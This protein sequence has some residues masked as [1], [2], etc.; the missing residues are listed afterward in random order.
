MKAIIHLVLVVVVREEQMMFENVISK[1]FKLN[2]EA[3]ATLKYLRTEVLICSLSTAHKAEKNNLESLWNLFWFWKPFLTAIC[4]CCPKY[5]A[6]IYC[7]KLLFSRLSTFHRFPFSLEIAS[8]IADATS[9]HSILNC[10]I[11]L[12]YGWRYS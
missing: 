5:L 10:I 8:A 11:L 7:N 9:P 12:L 1:I 3:I 4:I 6:T 2:A